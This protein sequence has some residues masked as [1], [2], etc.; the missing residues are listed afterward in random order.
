M[1]ADWL[2]ER[3]GLDSALVGDLSEECARGRSTVWYWRQI[4]A[5]IWSGLWSTIF[6]HKL[7]ALR[8]VA[9]GCAVNALW[10]F[11]W[12]RFLHIRLSWTPGISFDSIASLILILFTQV[13]TGWVV[14]RTHREHAIPV[15]FLFVL[16][17]VTW[18]L[19]GSLSDAKRL[20]VNSIDQRRLWPYL[21]WHLTP[22]SIEVAGLFCG[23]VIGARPRRQASST[24]NPQAV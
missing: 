9:T 22:I 8:A 15:V 10:L 16:W 12:V 1:A 24:T 20:L 13:I 7:F 6:H 5:S 18:Y 21:A 3:L 23:G 19:A 17:L 14:A 11:L 2:L 4:L